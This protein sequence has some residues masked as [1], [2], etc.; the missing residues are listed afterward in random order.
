MLAEQAQRLLVGVIGQPRLLAV[1]HPL[2]LLGQ[3]VVV[4]PH[5]PRGR[6]IGHAELEDHRAGDLGHLLEVARGTVRDPAEDDLLGG[7]PGERDLHHV[8]EL[9]LRVEVAVLDG[10]VVR[11]AERVAAS[12]DRHLLHRHHVAHQVRDA[13]HG[14]P[15]GRRGSASPSRSRPGAS[16]GPSARAPSRPRS[17][18]GGCTAGR[19][20]PRRSLPRSRCSRGRRR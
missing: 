8:E 1:A 7:T 14:R 6:D 5:R 12:D 16:E 9:L 15:R 3:R 20:G 11:E 2:R 4:G 13:A 10:E 19:C 17:P 18:P